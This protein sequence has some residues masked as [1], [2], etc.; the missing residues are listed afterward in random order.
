MDIFAVWFLDRA[1]RQANFEGSFALHKR[2]SFV[3]LALAGP[4][5]AFRARAPIPYVQAAILKLPHPY[6]RS[7]TALRDH[8]YN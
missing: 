1:K 4:C 7:A 5:L 6:I 8:A 3:W 2:S